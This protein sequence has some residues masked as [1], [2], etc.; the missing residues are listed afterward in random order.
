M[1]GA[2]SQDTSWYITIFNRSPEDTVI[3]HMDIEWINTSLTKVTFRGSPIWAP[4]NDPVP[5][6]QVL[7][8]YTISPKTR[9]I[10]AGE[11]G[12]S[13]LQFIFTG[14]THNVYHLKVYLTTAGCYV[15]YWQ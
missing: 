2:Y 4:E 12:G 9:T 11:M 13:L 5:P 8:F 7:T 1:S 6:P 14:T 3:D 15:E 10:P